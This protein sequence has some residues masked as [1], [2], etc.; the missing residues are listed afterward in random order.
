MPTEPIGRPYKFNSQIAARGAELDT[1]Y[2]RLERQGRVEGYLQFRRF[3]FVV[4][5]EPIDRF[6]GFHER[7]TVKQQQ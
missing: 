1:A 2:A 5:R 7:V 4:E 6:I 3:L